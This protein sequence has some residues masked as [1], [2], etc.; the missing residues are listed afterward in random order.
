L[1]SIDLLSDNF[2]N[3]IRFDAAIP[4][5]IGHDAHGYPRGA[6]SHAVTG[7]GDC[8]LGKLGLECIQDSFST[9]AIAGT[10]LADENA[11][12]LWQ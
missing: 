11:A 10:M 4:P 9:V 1:V 6:L 5:T 3:I 12:T 8:A 7:N 2:G